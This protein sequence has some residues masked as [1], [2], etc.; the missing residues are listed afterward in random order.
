MTASKSYCMN[1]GAYETYKEVRLAFPLSLGIKQATV[2]P[3]PSTS[4]WYS[5]R[6]SPS[7][8]IHTS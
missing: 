8:V 1:T 4:V 3:S 2:L 5:G 6:G 7:Q